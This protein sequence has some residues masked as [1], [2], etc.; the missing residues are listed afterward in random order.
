MHRDQYEVIAARRQ[1]YDSLLWQSPTLA[2]A[3][4]GFLL[5]I[6]LNAEHRLFAGFVCLAALAV[7]A[8]SIQ[9]FVKLR[10][11]EKRD[12]ELLAGHEAANAELE[13]L[14]GRPPNSTATAGDGAG[15]RLLAW[16]EN[17]SSFRWW[18]A[19]LSAIAVVDVAAFVAVALDLL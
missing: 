4:Q 7:G 14:H 17:Q 19:I 10:K 1:A 16:L 5:G 13:R 6:A 11:L 8:A 15:R 3:A 12:S 18:L 9:F 2:V